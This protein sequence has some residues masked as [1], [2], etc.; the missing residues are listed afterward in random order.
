MMDWSGERVLVTGAAGFLGRHVMAALAARASA[1]A[2]TAPTRAECDLLDVDACRA[3]LRVARPTI[4]IHAAGFSGGLGAV[5]DHPARFFHDNLAMGLNLIEGVREAGLAPSCR[6]VQLGHMTSYPADASQPLREEDL[7]AGPPPAE[8]APYGL[9]KRSLLTMLEAY[10][11]EHG[12]RWQYLIPGN[13]YGPGD[14]FDPARSHAV[15]ALVRRFVEA[16]ATNAAEV[17]CWGTGMAVRD[18][19][20]VSDAADAIVRAAEASDAEPTPIN[21]SS[22]EERTI[23]ELAGM[24]AAAAGFRG[25]TVWDAAKGDGV[26]RRVLDGSRARRLLGWSASTPLAQGL[27]RTVEHYRSLIAP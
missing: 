9:A 26:P 18:F 21:I 25:R 6:F 17:V 24:I 8:V 19:V 15:G 13:L 16:A 5:R 12:L 2:I 1:P 4:I 27:A 23:A 20:F 7:H 14:A 11:R 22:G 10:H 3:V